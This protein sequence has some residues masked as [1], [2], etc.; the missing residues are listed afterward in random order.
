MH[1]VFSIT[2]EKF[3][4]KIPSGCGVRAVFVFSLLFQAKQGSR[5]SLA[6]LEW[7]FLSSSMFVYSPWFVFG[8][9]F[10]KCMSSLIVTVSRNHRQLYMPLRTHYNHSF[11]SCIP[12]N[13]SY[14][15]VVV[16]MSSRICMTKLGVHFWSRRSHQWSEPHKRPRHLNLDI[17]SCVSWTHY[18]CIPIRFLIKFH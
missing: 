11:Y 15:L 13:M 18:R 17:P 7:T 4:L 3:E 6:S 5:G 14:S 12:Q 10:P 8:L 9:A 2:H 16:T 1:Y